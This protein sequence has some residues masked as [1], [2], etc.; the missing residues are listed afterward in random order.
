MGTEGEQR[1]DVEEHAGEEAPG[2]CRRPWRAIA[3]HGPMET[4]CKGTRWPGEASPR[5]AK[6]L[7]WAK[8]K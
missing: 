4:E 7:G 6:G 1:L 2:A 8:S 3:G 5:L